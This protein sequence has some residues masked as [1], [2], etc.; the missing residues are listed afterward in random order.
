MRVLANRVVREF[1][2]REDQRPADRSAEPVIGAAAQLGETVFLRRFS[3]L[4][5]MPTTTGDLNEMPLLAGQGV[6]LIRAVEP[7]ETIV[8]SMM[9]EVMEI[10]E[11]L[12][13]RG[14]P[15]A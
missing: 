2:G 10:I 7:A 4:V 12:N 3:S 13:G 9:A 15:S 8:R 6:G 5:P 1:E 11:R 14:A